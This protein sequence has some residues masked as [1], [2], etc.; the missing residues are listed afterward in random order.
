MGVNNQPTTVALA[1]GKKKDDTPRQIAVGCGGC[2]LGLI[3]LFA[4][5]ITAS[6]LLASFASNPLGAILAAFLAII[7]CVPYA[8]FYIWIDRNEREPWPLL[9][10]AFIWG[11]VGAVGLSIVAN[12]LFG[13]VALGLT[14]NEA[15]SSQLTASFSAPFF[16]EITKALALLIIFVGFPRHFDNVL[17]G[18]VYGALAGLGF[19]TVENYIYYIQNSGEMLQVFWIRGIV[20]GVGSH[21]VYTAITGA[22]FGAFR[23]MRKGFLRVIVVF[24]ALSLAMFV[25]FAWNTFGVLFMIGVESTVEV[26]L[27]R[28]P[29][30]ALVINIP[31]FVGV[32]ITVFFVLRHETKLIQE[33]LKDE[34]PAVVSKEDLHHLLPARRRMMREMKI[35][36]SGNLKEY[37]RVTK[38]N[39]M[40]VRLAFEKWHM[41]S[42]AGIGDAET[43]QQHAVEVIE[44]RTRLRG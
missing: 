15:I 9:I 5:L 43:A 23:V 37:S 29:L 19:A 10:A 11:S 31:F 42:E 34:D 17:D 22:G 8:A 20:A 41:R 26:L 18:I 38:R 16:E 40:L 39:K 21:A 12:T 1:M 44:L 36:F 7:I 24:A 4:L 27:L 35:L 32:L 28:M 33:Y 3:F 25:H 13:G 14:G 6:T 2:L 30:M